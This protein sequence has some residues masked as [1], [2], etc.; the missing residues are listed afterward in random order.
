MDA[1]GECV[2]REA[3]KHYRVHRS[4]AGARKHRKRSLR[5]HGQVDGDAVA[6]FNTALFKHIG[7]AAN[8]VFKLSVCNGAGLAIISLPN[9]RNLLALRLSVPVDTVV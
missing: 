6:F 5:D 2:G 1:T 3:S 8:F 7:K 9:N 4:H